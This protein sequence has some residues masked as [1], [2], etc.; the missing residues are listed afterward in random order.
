[1]V[2][3]PLPLS[4]AVGRFDEIDRRGITGVIAED[5]S[6]QVVGENLDVDGLAKSLKSGAAVVLVDE[7]A[8]YGEVL[9]RLRSVQPTAGVI[10]MARSPGR[11]FGRTLVACGVSCV[12]WTI[13]AAELIAAIHTAALGEPTFLA[14]WT[15][16]SQS[17][18]TADPRLTE[19]E[20]VVLALVSAGESTQAIASQLRVSASTVRTYLGRLV[21]KL[22]AQSRRDLVGLP[23][24][25]L[26]AS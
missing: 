16:D 12:A 1:M 15:S 14:A 2:E 7:L 3:W 8:A 18:R 13:S 25:L 19:K 6:L 5:R 20:L 9:P 11:S 17:G 22:E 26:R 23:T 10:V 4:V 21:V 24:S